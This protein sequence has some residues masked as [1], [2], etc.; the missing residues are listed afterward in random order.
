MKLFYARV[1]C[2]PTFLKHPSSWTC[3]ITL[4]LTI[5]SFPPTLLILFIFTLNWCDVGTAV[6]LLIHKLLYLH[7]SLSFLKAICKNICC[8]FTIMKLPG[9]I[10]AAAWNYNDS[11]H[12]FSFFE[13]LLR[14]SVTLC[15]MIAPVFLLWICSLYFLYHCF[16]DE[17]CCLNFLL[18]FEVL[19]QICLL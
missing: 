19:L 8:T 5:L 7:F 11:T 16:E 2:P 3:Y 17:G 14:G 18:K 9:N 1:Q 4:I 15:I 13:F 12:Y 6:L 10:K